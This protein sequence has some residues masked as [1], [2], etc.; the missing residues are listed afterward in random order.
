MK[1]KTITLMLNGLA[2]RYIG[3]AAVFSPDAIQ[4]LPE[5]IVHI[6][7]RIFT[8]ALAAALMLSLAIVAYAANLF[9]LRELFANPNRGQMPEEAAELIVTQNA[10]F[11]HDGWH[12]QVMESYCDEGTVAVTVCVSADTKYFVVPADA[13]PDDPLSE[14][15][16]SGEGTLRD[17]AR[18]EGK[19]LLFVEAVLDRD[20][21]GLSSAGQRFENISPQEMVIYFEGARS[22][23]AAVPTETTCTVV[24]VVFPPE[25][26]SYTVERYALP[27]T[28]SEGR[29]SQ[30]GLFVPR[31]PY[32][33]PGF[34]I[35]ALSLTQTP[36]GISLRLR[37]N[38]LDQNAANKLLTLRLV[39]V[40]FHGDGVIDPDS[41]AVFTQGKGDFGESPTIRFL[42]WD[43]K[44]IAEVSFA[45]QN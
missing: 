41:Y 9:G 1:R 34:E 6:R 20:T 38:T 21:L 36:L 31:D 37:L 4:D 7:K 10:E 33:V 19:T 24:A 42:D 39:G 18:K 26:D 23:D 15:G 8:F 32:A 45:E 30:I 40:E 14:I 25:T 28:L 44:L 43:K 2:D 13:D 29:S 27:V 35:G 22:E 11:E 17:Y 16:L 5:R 12:A 3:E